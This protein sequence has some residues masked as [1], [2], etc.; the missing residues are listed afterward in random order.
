MAGKSMEMTGGRTLLAIL[1]VAWPGARA[2][3]QGG[4]S[5]SMGGILANALGD[6]RSRIIGLVEAAHTLPG[7]LG[8]CW[9]RLRAN[10][11]ADDLHHL[12][13]YLAAFVIGGAVVQWLFFLVSR[14][15]RKHIL[16]GEENTLRQR[17]LL[18][19]RG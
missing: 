7:E 13:L 17:L 16:H 2:L 15:W 10:V 18:I 9:S 6:T 8:E 12:L 14:P 19:P 11:P 4:A 5:S 1:L 3:A